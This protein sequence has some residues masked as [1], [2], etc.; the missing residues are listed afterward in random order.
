MSK[1]QSKANHLIRF[2]PLVCIMFFIR[3]KYIKCVKYKVKQTK[4]VVQSEF[5]KVFKVQS[6]AEHLIQFTPLTPIEE[7]AQ[8]C[9]ALLNIKC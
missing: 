5:N 2:T 3:I 9:G 1:V 4:R 6:E 8:V 7:Q